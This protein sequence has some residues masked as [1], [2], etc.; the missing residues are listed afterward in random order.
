MQRRRVDDESHDARLMASRRRC[1]LSERPNRGGGCYSRSGSLWRVGRRR[2]ARP[3]RKAQAGCPTGGCKPGALW[4]E[5][6]GRVSRCLR[7]DGE[8]ISTPWSRLAGSRWLSRSPS[9]AR[10]GAQRTSANPRKT[11]QKRQDPRRHRQRGPCKTEA[12]DGLVWGFKSSASVAVGERSPGEQPGQIRRFT[13]SRKT[14]R[15][16]TPAGCA[17]R[18]GT[19]SRIRNVPGRAR[20]PVAGCGR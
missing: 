17:G 5:A 2:G 18:R 14:V 10:H 12:P 4:C 6:P 19:D 9:A 13:P 11:G 1:V 8:P 3:H 15:I 16:A 20:P 7:A